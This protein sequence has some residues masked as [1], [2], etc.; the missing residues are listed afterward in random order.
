[1]SASTF[2]VKTWTVGRYTVTMTLP[3][4]RQGAFKVLVEW[5]PHF[6]PPHSLTRAEA[7][8]YRRG[9]NAALAEL[10]IPALILD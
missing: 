2:I 9:R 6:P 3:A 5:A 4:I 10:G 8:E 1:M 7:E